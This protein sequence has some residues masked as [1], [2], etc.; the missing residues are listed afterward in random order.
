MLKLLFFTRF[1]IGY[2][3]TAK[4]YSSHA[5]ITSSSKGELVNFLFKINT[6]DNI[7]GQLKFNLKDAVA[8]NGQF[9]MTSSDGKGNGNLMVH[10]KTVRFQSLTLFSIITVISSVQQWT[11]GHLHGC[12]YK[13]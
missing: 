3:E 10:F 2:I 12:Y 6:G 1:D 13:T 8:A 7:N 9:Q 4:L 11:V 5:A